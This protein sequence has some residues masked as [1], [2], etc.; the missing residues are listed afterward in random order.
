MQLIHLNLNNTIQSHNLLTD[1]TIDQVLYK[2]HKQ[3]HNM[4]NNKCDH[5]GEEVDTIKEEYQK[6]LEKY[7]LPE[8]AT[9]NEEFD[10]SKIDCCSSE[11]FLRDVRKTI[12]TKLASIL[13]LTEILLNPTGGSMFHMYLVKGINIDEKEKLDEIFQIL[14]LLEIDSFKLDINYSEIGEAEFINKAF[15]KWIKMKPSLESIIDSLKAN[16]NKTA[17]K[18]IKTY[19]G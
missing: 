5:C 9:V 11:T 19:F 14:G 7:S 3:I 10:I 1:I 16:W 2:D 8:F 18:K 12:V 6:H 13:Q 17:T 4:E 15:G